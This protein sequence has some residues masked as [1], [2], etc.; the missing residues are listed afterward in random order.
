MYFYHPLIEVQH[1]ICVKKGLAIKSEF[2][3]L[4]AIDNEC[5]K[6]RHECERCF[7]K[8]TRYCKYILC[9][10]FHYAFAQQILKL[11]TKSNNK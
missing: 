5:R 4:F 6:I 7:E 1:T 10:I 9:S 8:P 3:S 11:E 2:V